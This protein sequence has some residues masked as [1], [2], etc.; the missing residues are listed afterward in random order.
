[1]IVPAQL[2]PGPRRGASWRPQCFS[3]PARSPPGAGSASYR[4]FRPRTGFPGR[5]GGPAE[6]RAAVALTH[7]EDEIKSEEQVFDT[8]GASFDR[9]RAG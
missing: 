1:M 6:G 4:H 8:L 2:V 9:H 7:P 5:T 3:L